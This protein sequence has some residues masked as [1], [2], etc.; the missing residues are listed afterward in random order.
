MPLNCGA[1]K[2]WMSLGQLGDQTNQSQGRSTLNIHWKDWYWSWSSSILVIQCKQ[3][4]HWKSPW[5]WERLRAGG[6]EGIRGWDGWTASPMQWTWTWANSGRW[7]GIGRSG[8]LQSTGSQ[9]VGHDRATEQQGYKY[10]HHGQF[11]AVTNMMT[12]NMELG[13]DAE[14][15]IIL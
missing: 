10:C 15:H 14:K 7:W 8:V 1:G 6:K 11:W 12:S 13:R 5:C 2:N 4:V 9:R 3:M